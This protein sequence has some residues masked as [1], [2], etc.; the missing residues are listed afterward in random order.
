MMRARSSVFCSIRS[1]QRRR[2]TARSFAGLA[3]HA[4]HAL[5]AASMAWQVSVVPMRGIVDMVPV[6]QRQVEDLG[7]LR[8]LTPPALRVF[9]GKDLLALPF[10]QLG[11][12]RHAG[13]TK[14]AGGQ[15]MFGATERAFTG[16][17]KSISLPC[18]SRLARS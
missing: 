8:R 10:I 16:H 15:P 6:G 7:A 4:A 11:V 14:E 5:S 12:P 2:I 17:G 1:N 3:R 13:N 9:Y 18:P